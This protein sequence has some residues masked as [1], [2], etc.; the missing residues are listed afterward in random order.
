MPIAIAA[1][2]RRLTRYQATAIAAYTLVAEGPP[3]KLAARN[4]PSS[5]PDRWLANHATIALS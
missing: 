1:P 5:V 4:G 3:S 2:M